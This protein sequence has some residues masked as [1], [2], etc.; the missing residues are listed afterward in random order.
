MVAT[1]TLKMVA[2][3]LIIVWGVVFSPAT[4]NAQTTEGAVLLVID[5]NAIDY[6]LEPF[7][8][9][10]DVK[11]DLI[12][13]VGVRDPLP[14]FS[15]NV[16]RQFVL[17]TGMEGN[18]SW[19]ALNSAPS[20][21][22]SESGSNDSLQNFVLAGPGLGSPDR[23]GDREALLAGIPG[24][25]PVRA[26]NAPLLVNHAV[27]AV[28]YDEDLS[29]AE[30]AAEMN[31]RGANLGLMAFRVMGVVSTASQWPGMT[32]ELLDVRETCTGQLET[33][34]QPTTQE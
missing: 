23:T 12:A 17:R 9:P 20:M 3:A 11:N 29:I 24:V 33:Y 14:F 21:W 2:G 1:K 4:T 15:A 6:G 28:I 32:I 26:N 34:P 22:D 13:A 16:G 8:V 18:D 30:G 31:L 10:P 5:R 25:T 19:F 7:Q 27:C